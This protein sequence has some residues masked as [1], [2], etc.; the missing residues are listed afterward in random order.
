MG[1]CLDSCLPEPITPDDRKKIEKNGEH[2]RFFMTGLGSAGKTTI[3]R[4]LFLLCNK[5]SNYKV[6]NENWVEEKTKPDD[7]E[8]WVATIRKNILDSIDIF[9]K[10]LKLNNDSFAD[11]KDKQFAQYIEEVCEQGDEGIEDLEPTADFIDALLKLFESEPIQNIWRKRNTINVEG[12]KLADGCDQFINSKKIRECFSENYIASDE[13]KVHSRKPTTDMSTYR[14]KINNM[15]IEINDVGGQRSEL[16]KIVDYLSQWSF[17]EGD[18]RSNFILLVVSMSD[19]NVKHDE[20]E[21]T[22]LDECVEYMKVLLNNKVAQNCG[23]FIFFNKKDRFKEKLS[24]PDCREDIQYLSPFLSPKQIAN[25]QRGRFSEQE[26]QKALSDKFTE[27]I[28]TFKDRE[29]HSYCKYT[30]AVDSK[31]MEGIFSAI[32]EDVINNQLMDILP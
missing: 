31:M 19:F 12:K 32:K 15:R 3:V 13:D 8:M 11:D 16:V 17:T 6:C 20:Y 22:L 1:N 29:R 24:D 14:F 27:A 5:V 18:P 28:K 7:N 2:I 26:M 30:C 10:Q 4:Q 25:F 9:I 21:G 23:L